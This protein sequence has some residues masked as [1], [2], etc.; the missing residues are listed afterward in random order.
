MQQNS[1][2]VTILTGFLGAGK[3][4]LLN[5]IISQN[6]QTQYA[7]I[8]NEFGKVPL[9]QELIDGPKEGIFELANGCICCN[10]NEELLKVLTKLITS[11]FKFDHLLIET[12][13][14]ADPLS[15]AATFMFDP[16]LQ[17]IFSLDGIIALAD[18][19]TVLE[20]IEQESVTAQQL[21]AAHNILLNKTDLL[22]KEEWNKVK[23]VLASLNPFAEIIPC[24][25]GQVDN[26]HL[27]DLRKRDYKMVE[28]A[29]Q[30]IHHQHG[31][32]RSFTWQSGNALDLHKF[33][34]WLSMFLPMN[35][36]VYRV[37]GKLYSKTYD[38]KIIVQSVG[39]QFYFTQGS[40]FEEER[41][42]N[43]LVF[44]GNNLDQESIKKALSDCEIN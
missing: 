6:P 39:T 3:T 29:D 24:Q 17:G 4:T 22:P 26:E 28:K 13:G 10:I 14:I 19:P 11:D 38:R 41:G 42:D 16:H 5:H 30:P 44:I 12:T 25:Y 9:D 8:E 43:M 23:E 1:I 34:A 21:S 15:V 18:A 40:L 31:Q 2:K 36:S 20:R 32:I 33:E 35:P 37:K 7:I 27:F